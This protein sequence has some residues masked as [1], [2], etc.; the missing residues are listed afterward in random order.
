MLTLLAIRM[1]VNEKVDCE[2]LEILGAHVAKFVAG[3]CFT[4]S[5]YYDIDYDEDD[6]RENKHDQRE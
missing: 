2:K 3:R 6:R 5:A 4:G 1:N